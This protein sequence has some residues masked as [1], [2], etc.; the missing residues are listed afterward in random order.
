MLTGLMFFLCAVGVLTFAA[1]PLVSAAALGAAY[2]VSKTAML[3]EESFLS[4]LSVLA[5]IGVAIEWVGA[6]WEF[7]TALP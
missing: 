5:A 3:D 7:I 1:W 4:G 6:A 2:C